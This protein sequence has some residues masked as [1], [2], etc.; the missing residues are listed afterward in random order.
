MSFISSA[1]NELAGPGEWYPVPGFYFKV[2]VLGI[3][4]STDD[5]SFKEVS[6]IDVRMET[7]TLSEGGINNHEW[8]V[9]KGVKYSNLVLKRGVMP[10]TSF[11]SLWIQSFIA[12]DITEPISP[13]NIIVTLN[14]E[15]GIPMYG[16]WFSNAY[17]VKWSFDPL[18]SMKNDYL[19][20]SIE[21]SYQ[22][23]VQGSV[24][25]LTAMAAQQ[26]M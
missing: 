25:S 7:E 21:F 15:Q 2:M 13:K 17:P 11:L 24:A 1:I 18:D 20:E 14:N 3:V 16:W 19:V 12:E 6:G 23:F 26:M 10:S 8:V 9:P 4:P 22:F 5:C